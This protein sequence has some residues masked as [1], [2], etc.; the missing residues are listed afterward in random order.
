M[1]IY[2]D[3]TVDALDIRLIPDAEVAQS[4][5][6]DGRRT[7]DLNNSGHVVSIEVM[8]ASHGFEVLD[9]TAR[10]G[11]KEFEGDLLSLAGGRLPVAH[12]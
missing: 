10:Y 1:V 8:G 9:I 7:V 5:D 11:L 2:Y 3:S 4:V 6:I 12:P